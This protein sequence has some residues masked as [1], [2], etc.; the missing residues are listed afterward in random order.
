LA[1]PVL[2]ALFRL[3]RAI[4]LAS[5]QE[6]PVACGQALATARQVLDEG[7]LL[8]LFPEGGITPD[9]ER[10]EFTG[11]L[12]QILQTHPVPVVPLALQSPPGGYLSRTAG[13]TALRRRRRLFSRVGLVVAPALPAAQVDLAA[14]RRQ[15]QVLSQS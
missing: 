7:G 9:G 8:G 10:A 14:L 2:G 6:D 5:Q 3:A 13:G 11:G 4:P 1:V 12:M 15:V